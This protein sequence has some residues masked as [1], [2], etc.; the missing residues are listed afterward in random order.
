M[1]SGIEFVYLNVNWRPLRIVELLRISFVFV[2]LSIFYP[3]LL[4]PFLFLI[5][6]CCSTLSWK[7]CRSSSMTK[8]ISTATPRL[9][10]ASGF[11]Y[12][13]LA[14]PWSI[15]IDQLLSTFGRKWK[16]KVSMSS[17]KSPRHWVWHWAYGLI[18]FLCVWDTQKFE[19]ISL[20]ATFKIL[21]YM[22]I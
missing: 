13:R 1:S 10:S 20:F 15:G 9:W 17:W 6:L 11:D 3:Y 5:Y 7:S 8:K 2:I 16:S 22:V 14:I 12:F 18:S 4:F 21:L 19:R